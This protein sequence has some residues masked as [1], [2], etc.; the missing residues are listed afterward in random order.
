VRGKN[1]L[2]LTLIVALLSVSVVNLGFS[3]TTTISVLPP[4][5]TGKYPG[6]SFSVGIRITDA[7]NVYSWEFALGY[8]PYMDILAVT[9]VVEGPFLKAGGDTYM[10]SI[11]DPFEGVVQ[12]GCTLTGEVPGVY[13]DGILAIVK[14]VVLE[15]GECALDLHGT[16]LVDPDGAYLAHETEDGHYLGLTADLIPLDLP[17]QRPIGGG[18]EQA[19]WKKTM[20]KRWNTIETF[21]AEVVNTGYA[22]LWMRTEYTSVNEHTG[23]VVTVYSGQEYFP[24]VSYRT[25]VLYVNEE[26]TVWDHWTKYGT[27]PY[28]DVAGDGSYIEAYEEPML[29]NVYGFEDVSLGPYDKIIDVVLE[30]YTQYPGGAD[31]DMDM[32]TYCFTPADYMFAWLGSLYGDAAWGWHT[33]RWIGDHV[34]D[35]VPAVTTEA[36]L[37][38][39]SCLFYY[40]TA[41]G[42]PHG[43]MRIDSARLIVLI[44]T[45][46]VYQME[47][48]WTQVDPGETVALPSALWHLEQQNTGKWYTTVSMQYRYYDPYAIP[49][50]LLQTGPT[51]F[52]YEWWIKGEGV[53]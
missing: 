47:P 19:D 53:D 11:I 2:W 7:S 46:G 32:D 52:T 49:S 1:I 34:S 30:G 45:G 39:F 40:W 3:Q 6:D 38:D 21:T 12:V 22:P 28:L 13:G 17:T 50:I 4:L 27:S 48:M 31:Q 37:N 44:E 29:S 41:D 26:I 9:D 24:T 5:T 42:V 25:E 43:D 8:A 23:E 10:A 51:T 35:V 20:V 15:A 14:F 33:P 16:A 36:G 18:Q